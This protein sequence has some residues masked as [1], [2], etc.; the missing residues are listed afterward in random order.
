MVEKWT[1]F[2][3]YHDPTPTD[4]AWP[5]YGSNGITYVRLENSKILVQN[6]KNRD[7]RLTFWK[8]IFSS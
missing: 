8:Q 2:A 3:T 4:N 7:E 5:A 1:N 6:D